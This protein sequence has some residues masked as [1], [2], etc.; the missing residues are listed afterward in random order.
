M[1]NAYTGIDHPN[2]EFMQMHPGVHVAL[3]MLTPRS[4][5]RAT[6]VSLP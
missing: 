6:S 3:Q 2:E 5:L 4:L 1:T